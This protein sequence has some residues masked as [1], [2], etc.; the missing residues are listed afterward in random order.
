MKSKLAGS[1]GRSISIALMLTAAAL[2]LPGGKALQSGPN[3][4]GDSITV[5][6]NVSY[7]SHPLYHLMDVY[8]PDSS[9]HPG[10]YPMFLVFHGGG[11]VTGSKDGALATLCTRLAEAGIVAASANY[12][13]QTPPLATWWPDTIL[14]SLQAVSDARRAIAFLQARAGFLDIDPA[15]FFLGGASAGSAVALNTTVMD[16]VDLG[17]LPGLDGIA[18]IASLWGSLYDLEGHLTTNKG[19]NYFQADDPPVSCIHGTLDQAIPY[20]A[21]EEIVRQASESGVYNE[22]HPLEGEGHSPWHRMDDIAAWI[23]AFIER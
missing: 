23:I 8:V 2:F 10:P 4:A 7:G 5:Y 13:L 12:T 20:S 9:I 19:V 11:Y 1:P 3:P 6:S 17:G 15:Q 21:S 14:A 18:G 22:I 16:P